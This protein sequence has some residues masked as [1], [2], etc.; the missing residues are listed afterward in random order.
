MRGQQD[1]T[2]CVHFSNTFSLCHRLLLQLTAHPSAMCCV[3]V[4]TLRVLTVTDGG[5]SKQ[6][7]QINKN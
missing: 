6:S 7:R 3:V 4:A 1:T 2:E 5:F